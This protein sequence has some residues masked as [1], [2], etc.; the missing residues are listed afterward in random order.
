M[1]QTSSLVLVLT[2]GINMAITTL[3]TIQS[4]GAIQLPPRP[5]VRE[6]QKPLAPLSSPDTG[7]DHPESSGPE[8]ELSEKTTSRGC[9]CAGGNVCCYRDD[10]VDCSFGICGLG[11]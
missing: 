2:L 7:L 1:K 11:V 6:K 3:P 9:F 8:V 4:A 5:E 10:L